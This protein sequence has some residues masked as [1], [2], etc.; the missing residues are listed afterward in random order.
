MHTNELYHHGILGQ[1]WGVR[2]YQNP[3]GTL[4]D[5]GKKRKKNADY[6][7]TPSVKAG[8]DK[9]PISPAEK[10]TKGASQVIENASDIVGTVSKL[11]Q[12][13]MDLSSMSSKDLQDAINR[14]NLERQYRS[15]TEA[16]TKRG[17]ETATDILAVTGSLVGIT[18]GVLGIIGAIKGK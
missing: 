13:N 5:A 4:T 11:K 15:L 1:K 9:A 16:D 7:L 14:M 10:V 12:N 6:W 8:K 18:A 3:D 17:Y 2:R